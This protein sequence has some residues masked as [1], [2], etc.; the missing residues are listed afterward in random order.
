LYT[1]AHE[2]GVFQGWKLLGVN[3]LKWNNTPEMKQKKWYQNDIEVPLIRVEPQEK[4]NS[5]HIIPTQKCIRQKNDLFQ[6]LISPVPILSSKAIGAMHWE[7]SWENVVCFQTFSHFFLK[8]GELLFWEKM[9]KCWETYQIS[10]NFLTIYSSMG[11]FLAQ[12]FSIPVPNMISFIK[13]KE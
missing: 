13:N 7:K 5:F 10:R 2:L 1:R 3:E 9:G 4:K 12:L 8:M 6:I 11:T